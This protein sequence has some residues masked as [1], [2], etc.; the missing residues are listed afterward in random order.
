MRSLTVSV[1]LIVVVLALGS[2]E[3]YTYE[4]MNSQLSDTKASLSAQ[5]AADNSLISRLRGE[6]SSLQSLVYGSQ[7]RCGS[8]IAAN[9]TL[10]ADIGPCSGDGLVIGRS[11]VTLDCAGHTISSVSTGMILGINLTSVTEVTVENCNVT[12][13]HHGFELANSS[14]DTLTGNTANDNTQIG[15]YL[16]GSSDSALSGDTANHNSWYGFV[17]MG[18]SSGNNLTA[19]TASKNYN[20]GFGLFDSPGNTLT[21]N[22]ADG[23]VW[24]IYNYAAGFYLHNSSGS[25]LT[26]NTA[27]NN[28]DTGFWLDGSSSGALSGNTANGNYFGFYLTKSS[29]SNLKGDTASN[30]TGGFVLYESSNNTLSGSTAD[31]NTN[32]F[33]TSAPSNTFTMNTADKNAQSGYYDLTKGTGTAGTANTYSLDECSGNGLGCSR[34][35]GLGS[36]QP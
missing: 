4:S 32:G 26:D 17:L 16:D 6:V 25:T 20:G 21:G 36:P 12:G 2:L 3:Y 34:P 22:T 15:F 9:A 30:N 19:N 14:H 29:N 28:T 10:S 11:G 27:D 31:D 13:F 5:I 35:S 1:V 23:N 24:T 7:A 8:V 18:Y 33:L